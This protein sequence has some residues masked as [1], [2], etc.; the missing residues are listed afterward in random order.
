[1]GCDLGKP[2]IGYGLAIAFLLAIVGCQADG[3]NSPP[4][5]SAN[6]SPF[7][8]T[9][10]YNRNNTG[11]YGLTLIDSNSHKPTS[12]DNPP[13]CLP[14]PAS[15]VQAAPPG[16]A[17]PPPGPAYQMAGP[18]LA[19]GASVPGA[20]GAPTGYWVYQPASGYG[21]TKVVPVFGPQPGQ[22][23]AFGQPASGG[24]TP[25][26]PMPPAGYP[27]N[28]AGGYP[29]MPPNMAPGGGPYTGGPPAPQYSAVQ[30]TYPQGSIAPWNPS[31]GNSVGAGPNV[32]AQPP[33]F[34]SMAAPPGASTPAYGNYQT[35]PPPNYGPQAAALPIAPR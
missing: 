2:W 15:G 1:M 29:A 24:P 16:S 34:Q 3:D 14:P 10:T 26:G 30:A 23:P 5:S 8:S 32:G 12:S 21:V 35:Q 25:A 22:P 17:Y 27:V 13:V 31:G 33:V 4:S 19:T 7:S 11:D 28:A 9:A 6:R 18:N 20:A